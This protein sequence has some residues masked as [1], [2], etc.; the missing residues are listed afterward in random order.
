LIFHFSGSDF[1]LVGSEHDHDHDY[2]HENVPCGNGRCK[3]ENYDPVE[4]SQLSPGS[5]D[6][7]FSGEHGSR[8]PGSGGLGSFGDISESTD[9]EIHSPGEGLIPGHGGEGDHSHD[10]HSDSE[11]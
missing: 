4:G 2:S 1:Q 6:D 8:P 3:P 10:H 9:L 5:E 11:G 7:N